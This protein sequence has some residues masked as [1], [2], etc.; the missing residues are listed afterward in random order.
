MPD[1]RYFL[2]GVAAAMAAEGATDDGTIYIPDTQ[3][4]KDRPFLLDFLDEYSFAMIVTGQPA[5]HITN[6]PTVLD[7]APDG[8]G[9]IW[10]H[11]AKA[12]PQNGAMSGPVTAVFRGPHGYISPNWYQA[13]NSVPTW[14]FATVHV[15]GT[16]RR[17]E[18]D[19]DVATGLRRLVERNEARYG[20]GD[21]WHFDQLPDSYLRGM[22][23]AIVAYE[24]SIERVEAKF[25]LGQERSEQDRAG[26]LEGLAESPKERD[27][28]ALTRA[29]YNR[30]KPPVPSKKPE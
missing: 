11:L 1:R 23:G 13:K 3:S 26:M 30:L 18:G 16:P 14:N 8:W 2:L 27:L 4:E 12:N 25:K 19:A 17:I 21:S 20:G 5:V 6:V 24:M 29:Y 9:K 7:R 22:R 28:P 10:W 15:T